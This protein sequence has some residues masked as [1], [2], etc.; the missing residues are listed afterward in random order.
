MFSPERVDRWGGFYLGGAVGA[1]WSEAD[2]FGHNPYREPFGQ[3]SS[4]GGFTGGAKVGYSRQIGSFVVG[5]EADI[6]TLRAEA[7]T[8]YTDPLPL[9]ST[10]ERYSASTNWLSTVRMRMGVTTSPFMLVYVTGGFALTEIAFTD[11]WSVY[12]AQLVSVGLLPGS[13]GQTRFSVGWTVGIGLECALGDRWSAVLEAL[14]IDLGT[15]GFTQTDTSG[16][17]YVTQA[18]DLS[19]GLTRIGINYRF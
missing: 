4:L 16:R 19:M 10:S 1:S 2:G 9:W 14:Y 3:R 8:N 18:G 5:V 6:Q 12:D 17:A 13:I 11:E 7:T 15:V